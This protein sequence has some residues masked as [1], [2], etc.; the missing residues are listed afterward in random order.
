MKN[1]V[2]R[3]RSTVESKQMG[4]QMFAMRPSSANI[5]VH[6]GSKVMHLR[7][8]FFIFKVRYGNEKKSKAIPVT[9]RGG[10]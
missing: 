9:G 10:P 5:L 2:D 7:R 1:H 6:S 3:V 8:F 4:Y